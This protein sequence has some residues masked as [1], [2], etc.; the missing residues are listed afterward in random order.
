M[1]IEGDRLTYRVMSHP[2][3][4]SGPFAFVLGS[5]ADAFG[6]SQIKPRSE[7]A[8][9]NVEP[10]TVHVIGL[11]GALRPGEMQLARTALRNAFGAE[12]DQLDIRPAQARP[13]SCED[14]LLTSAQSCRVG[15]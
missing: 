1:R 8:V 6:G 13:V 11:T 3:R 10:G 9:I 2:Y 14:G 5:R 4:R 15:G 7:T 12:L